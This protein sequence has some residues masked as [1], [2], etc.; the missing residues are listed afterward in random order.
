MPLH[1][2]YCEECAEVEYRLI[3]PGKGGCSKSPFHRW[4]NLGLKGDRK[5]KC[6]QCHKEVG[7][8]KKPVSYGCKEAIFHEW[9]E[10]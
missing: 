5:F 9:K 1:V 10:I 3:S 8:L 2:Y 6:T 7:T 4:I